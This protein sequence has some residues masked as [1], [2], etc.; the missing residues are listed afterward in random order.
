M[1]LF[2]WGTLTTEVM[3]IGRKILKDGMDTKPKCKANYF[4]IEGEIYQVA[5]TEY[6]VMLQ[7]EKSWGY[8][9]TTIMIDNVECILFVKSPV[10]DRNYWKDL[11]GRIQ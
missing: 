3:G 10:Y 6:D 5:Q 7:F 8:I 9:P 2:V 11:L 1:N 4:G